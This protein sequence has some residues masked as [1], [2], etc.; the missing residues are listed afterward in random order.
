MPG[1][2]RRTARLYEVEPMSFLRLTIPASL[3]VASVLFA[4][5]CSFQMQAGS[6]KP[7]TPSGTSSTTPESTPA[8]PAQDTVAKRPLLVSTKRPSPKGMSKASMDVLK[9]R[10]AGGTTPPPAGSADP[11]FVT[12]AT[13]FGGP[14]GNDTSYVGLLYFTNPGATTLPAFDSLKP[15]GALFTNTLNIA[16]NT[17][18][19][20][21]PGV[22][23]RKENFA[24]RYE[25]PLTVSTEGDYAL[26]MVSDDGAKLYID[27]MLILDNDGVKAAAAE[28]S[29]PVHLIA[30]THTIRIDYFHTTGPVALQVFVKPPTT[31]ETL[32]GTKL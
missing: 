14:D 4:S 17:T 13:P 16:P 1:F 20:G 9:R 2:I 18:F 22:D 6:K 28:A 8:S 5:G 12:A 7:T 27:D 19:A 21:F 29:G 30:A 32:L 15:A 23:G 26:R 11:R 10:Q 24:L 3:A 25:A 31:A